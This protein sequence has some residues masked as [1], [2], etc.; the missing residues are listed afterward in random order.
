MFSILFESSSLTIIRV[1]G[2]IAILISL[3]G[4]L[5]AAG[6]DF[7][8]R[9]SAEK[10]TS[11]IDLSTEPGRL[12]I[13]K[14]RVQASVA[15]ATQKRIYRKKE[16]RKDLSITA[17]RQGAVASSS[18]TII[19]DDYYSYSN[20]GYID[21]FDA[22]TDEIEIYGARIFSARGDWAQ[23]SVVITGRRIDV[24]EPGTIV[25]T[26]SRISDTEPVGVCIGFDCEGFPN[27]YSA[28][29]SPLMNNMTPTIWLRF[30]DWLFPS[31]PVSVC[32][33]V[34]PEAL[35]MR[36][37]TSLDD[38]DAR[39]LAAGQAMI[40]ARQAVNTIWAN[41]S[42]YSITFADGGTQTYRWTSANP[43]YPASLPDLEKGDGVNKCP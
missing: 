2:A 7:D 27:I 13:A 34:N 43:A 10:N 24:Y 21:C 5:L 26:A 36:N 8:L 31:V 17:G 15:A 16:N 6:T 9:Q 11:K 3:N 25:V 29:E 42:E 18:T 37:T 22:Q 38:D 40:Q 32:A 33:I 19:C 39:R 1:F 41:N 20:Y 28:I 12:T 14:L 30:V 4:D 23:D 35:A